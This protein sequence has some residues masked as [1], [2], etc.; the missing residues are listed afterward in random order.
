MKDLQQQLAELRKRME[1]A[2][3]RA[4]RMTAA[5]PKKSS[6]VPV[7]DWVN[8][9][10]VETPW[11]RHFECERTWDNKH[12]HGSADI[13]ALLEM[14]ADFLG[15]ISA[16]GVPASEPAKWAFLDTETT[17]VA[18]GSGTC[19]FLVGVG[20]VTREGFRLK[21]YFMRD[22]DEEASMLGAL[23]SDLEDAE[24]LV[25]YN[26]KA[27]DVPLL[28]TRYRLKRARPPFAWMSH[29]DLLF[30]ARRLWRLR[31]E[32]CRLMELETQILGFE[33]DGDVPGEMIPHLY[34]E[35]LR[36]RSPARL[37]PVFE[38]NAL[39][40]VSLACLTSIV[41]RA[42]QSPRDGVRHGSEMV[43]MARWMRQNERVEEALEMFRRAVK[44]NLG[45]R[46]LFRS[47][48]DMALLERKQGRRDSAVALWS[49]LAGCRNPH[50]AAALVELA[51]HYEHHEKNFA[52]AL[53]FVNAALAAGETDELAK[54]RDRLQRLAK[55]PRTARLL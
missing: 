11:G 31:L 29:L 1:R 28:E 2:A 44:E 18:G 53:D 49:E 48:W 54:R 13:G 6:F 20:R 34:F 10:V 30:G 42:F 22:F 14:P 32:S 51:K 52:M 35:Y 5:Q 21:Q 46:L 39:D 55:A 26:G 45:D 17:G 8:G 9:Q 43:S 23:A 50:Q 38:H 24:T 36:L 7:E 33:R 47:L 37:A 41:P 40:I 19:A 25:T 3:A 27:F 4:D 15:E 12:R 16:G